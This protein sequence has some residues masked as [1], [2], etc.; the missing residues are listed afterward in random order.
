MRFT[1]KGRYALRAT[2]ALAQMAKED[3]MI[4]L[5]AISDA[6]NI[7][8]VFLEQIFFKLKKAGIVKSV[9]GPAGGF[10]FNRPIDSL[11]VK[12]I[13]DAA[14]EEMTMLPCDRNKAKCE[15]RSECISHK[16]IVMTTEL[17][18]NYL[19]GITLKALLEKEEF[20]PIQG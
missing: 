20:K 2:I 1:T 6:E 18:N 17:V 13:M 3:K 4:T 5:N 9:R 11:T 10:S 19:N 12:E 15:R 8:H 14:G 7:S 16:L